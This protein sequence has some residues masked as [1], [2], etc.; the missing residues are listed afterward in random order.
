VRAAFGPP[1]RP[2]PLGTDAG[3]GR[4]AAGAGL[5]VALSTATPLPELIVAYV[6]L[7]AGFGLV[8]PPISNA[9]VSG[10]PRAQAGVAAAV[11][12]TSR[13]I[14]AVLGVAVTGS[15]VAGAGPGSFVTASH[16]GWL[17][18]AVCGRWVTGMGLAD[19]EPLGP[20]QRRPGPRTAHRPAGGR[21]S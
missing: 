15:L 3:R 16:A 1:G 11:A 9:A 20:A 14:G 2:R 7:G 17:V 21:K 6:I 8:N 13:Q 10:M 12:S 18:I 5:F 4:I 19:D